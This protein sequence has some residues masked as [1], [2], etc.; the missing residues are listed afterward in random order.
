MEENDIS[1]GGNRRTGEVR[2]I[3]MISLLISRSTFYNYRKDLLSRI[4]A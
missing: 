2:E 4:Q 3:L 1:F